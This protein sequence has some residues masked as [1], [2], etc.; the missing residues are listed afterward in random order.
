[1]LPAVAREAIAAKLDGRPPNV[2]EATGELATSAPLF[3]TLRIEGDLRGCMGEL[4]ARYPDLVAETVDRA[5]VAAFGDPRFPP[6]QASELHRCDIDVTILGPLE[7]VD[8]PDSL[9]ALRYGVEVSDGDGRR[10]V[11][12]PAI[13]GVDTVEYQL[14]VAR[15]KAG[16]AADVEMKLRRFEAYRYEE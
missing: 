16:I 12:L 14:K 15:R 6:L 5:V 13:E 3:V 2:A 8:S 11:L 1:M 4:E 9:D 7:V 10:A